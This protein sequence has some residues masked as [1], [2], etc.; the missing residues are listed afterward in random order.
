VSADGRTGDGAGILFDIPDFFFK[1]YVILLFQ[2]RAIC[3]RNGFH[4]KK[5]PS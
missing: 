2:K 1:K 5:K 4:Q 3:R